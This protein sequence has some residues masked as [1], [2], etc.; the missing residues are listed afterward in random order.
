MILDRIQLFSKINKIILVIGVNQFVRSYY[1]VF[2]KK[3]RLEKTGEKIN[4]DKI[5][6]KLPCLSTL[7]DFL[8]T[9]VAW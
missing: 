2:N 3:I 7:L 6:L 8:K 9:T 4:Q 5:F 1:F